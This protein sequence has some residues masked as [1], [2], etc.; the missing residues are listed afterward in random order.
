MIY[1]ICVSCDHFINYYSLFN[2][3]FTT[4]SIMCRWHISSLTQDQPYS[5]SPGIHP[6]IHS[7]PHTRHSRNQL[8]N[9]RVHS[10]SGTAQVRCIRGYRGYSGHACSQR[11]R[12][13]PC[14]RGC[15]GNRMAHWPAV[16]EEN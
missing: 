3:L 9:S 5:P 8:I 4:S 6:S 12:M 14:A 7:P 15:V 1:A 2:L 10:Q 13:G 11:F 16:R